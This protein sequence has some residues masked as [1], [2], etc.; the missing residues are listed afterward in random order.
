MPAPPEPSPRE[1]IARAIVDTDF[2]R[3]L[4]PG[5]TRHDLMTAARIAADQAAEAW[6]GDNGLPIGES[7]ADPIRAGVISA[8]IRHG[9]EILALIEQHCVAAR[10]DA[11]ADAHGMNGF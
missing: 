1:L 11:F 4:V 7:V 2:R 9:S 8:L 5:T 10:E 3:Q 6:E